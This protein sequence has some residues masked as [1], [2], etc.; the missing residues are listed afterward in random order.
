MAILT[1]VSL[2][3]M[4][5]LFSC[6]WGLCFTLKAERTAEHGGTFKEQS[7]KQDI[8]SLV[9]SKRNL[10]CFFFFLNNLSKS[11]KK[12]H[13]FLG[14]QRYEMNAWLRVRRGCYLYF[15]ICLC[16]RDAESAIS[17]FIPAAPSAAHPLLRSY[18]HSLR[19]PLEVHVVDIQ[20]DWQA[21]A[22]S[23]SLPK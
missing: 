18:L 4:F 17:S 23:L 11:E 9:R 14:P 16:C 20:Y 10:W 6:V 5:F 13:S 22:T 12:E 3:Y 19:A 8:A 15:A 21:A 7:T 1:L 2:Y